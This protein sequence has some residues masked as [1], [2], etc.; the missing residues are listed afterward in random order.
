[1]VDRH[2]VLNQWGR[3]EAPLEAQMASVPKNAFYQLQT[4]LEKDNLTTGC[5][6]YFYM[7]F[8]QKEMM[9]LF[10]PTDILRHLFKLSFVLP[11]T[12]DTISS[13]FRSKIRS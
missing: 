12:Q 2:A 4:T 10:M 7:Y 3:R 1:M 5:C 8:L 9:K 6:I 11:S 13:T